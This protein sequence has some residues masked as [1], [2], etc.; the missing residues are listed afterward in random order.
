MVSHGLRKE[1]GLMLFEPGK[2]CDQVGCSLLLKE[3]T[4]ATTGD[5]GTAQTLT[6]HRYNAKVLLAREQWCATISE[7]GLEISMEQ[8]SATNPHQLLI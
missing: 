7:A 4:R 3:W 6:F 8:S 2:S 5:H 1:I